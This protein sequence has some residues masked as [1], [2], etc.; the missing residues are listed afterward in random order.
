MHVLI[1]KEIR[2]DFHSHFPFSIFHS[3]FS[4]LFPSAEKKETM[5]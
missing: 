4:I 3:P 5:P 2:K 1:I